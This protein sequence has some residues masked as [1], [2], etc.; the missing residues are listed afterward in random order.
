M[1]DE[2][3]LNRRLSRQSLAQK[4]RKKQENAENN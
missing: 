3:N 4:H 1:Y 2:V